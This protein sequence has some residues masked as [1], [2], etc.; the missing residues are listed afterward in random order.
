MHQHPLEQADQHGS[1]S[2]T[3]YFARESFLGSSI[4]LCHGTR[5]ILQRLAT[6]NNVDQ[7]IYPH[8]NLM[9]SDLYTN[10]KLF[11]NRYID[12]QI[13]RQHSADFELCLSR[14][15]L[16]SNLSKDFHAHFQRGLSVF[17][18]K[19]YMRHGQAISYFVAMENKGC[20]FDP[21][22]CFC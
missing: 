21:K 2:I 4:K 15:G 1:L 19:S 11:D 22:V 9:L 18:S 13:L 8:N 7:S 14:G 17:H 12:S 3:S 5:Y 20:S 16:K 10:E 6:W